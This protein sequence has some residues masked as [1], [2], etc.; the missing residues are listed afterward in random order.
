MTP[1]YRRGFFMLCSLELHL[2][3]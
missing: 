3:L 1:N 2:N